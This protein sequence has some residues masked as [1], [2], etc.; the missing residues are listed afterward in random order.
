MFEFQFI[1]NLSQWVILEADL[2]V[3]NINNNF[4]DID[5]KNLFYVLVNI[6]EK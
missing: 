3:D 1:V 5:T 2:F 4:I 6:C